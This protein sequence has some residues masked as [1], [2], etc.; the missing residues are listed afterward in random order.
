MHVTVI[1]TGGC[2]SFNT[3]VRIAHACT[4]LIAIS[5]TIR[6]HITNTESDD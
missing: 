4:D 3:P 1:L 5:Q 2:W 6:K